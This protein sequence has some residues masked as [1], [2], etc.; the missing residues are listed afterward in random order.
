MV[1][2]GESLKGIVTV[3]STVRNARTQAPR[4]ELAQHAKPLHDI[5]IGRVLARAA[6][7]RAIHNLFEAGSKAGQVVLITESGTGL[8]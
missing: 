5:E 1:P 2:A 7:A 4:A 8:L 3:R 6:K